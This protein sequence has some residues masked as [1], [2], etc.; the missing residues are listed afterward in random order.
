MKR[1]TCIMFYCCNRGFKKTWV[2]ITI[3]GLY[4]STGNSHK[5]CY[6]ITSLT[7]HFGVCSLFFLYVHHSHRSVFQINAPCKLNASVYLFLLENIHMHGVM[8]N[9]ENHLSIWEGLNSLTSGYSILDWAML[10]SK[11]FNNATYW[12]ACCSA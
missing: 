11:S 12:H 10:F 6:F 5:I 1:P 4:S 8:L 7:I 2:I 3:R 9:W